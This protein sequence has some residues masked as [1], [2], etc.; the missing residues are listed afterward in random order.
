MSNDAEQEAIQTIAECVD[1]LQHLKQGNDKFLTI[2]SRGAELARVA[3]Q[4]L[5]LLNQGAPLMPQ[6]EE[7]WAMVLKQA[8]GLEDRAFFFF[9]V[10]SITLGLKLYQHPEIGV[11]LL[12]RNDEDSHAAEDQS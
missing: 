3:R 10:E 1:V 11:S 8:H 9:L 7:E 2:D 12:T 4:A 5:Y 6:V